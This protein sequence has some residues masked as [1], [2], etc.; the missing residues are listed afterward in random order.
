MSTDKYYQNKTKHCTIGLSPADLK[1]LGTLPDHP[2]VGKPWLHPTRAQGGADWFL[3]PGAVWSDRA[4]Y[5]TTMTQGVYNLQMFVHCSDEA[6]FAALQ[7]AHPEI[8]PIKDGS[9][10]KGFYGAA[11]VLMDVTDK[12][13]EIMNNAVAY[14]SGKDHVDSLKKEMAEKDRLMVEVKSE[15]DKIKGEYERMKLELSLLKKK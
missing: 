4:G 15:T 6:E 5:F 2:P 12:H 3:P 10:L 13:D 9:K 14:M 11:Y 8:V 1:A 7:A